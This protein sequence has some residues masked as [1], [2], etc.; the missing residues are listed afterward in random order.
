MG[1]IGIREA[2]W[3]GYAFAEYCFQGWQAVFEI[4]TDMESLH[5]GQGLG[6]WGT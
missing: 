1:Y 6:Y 5:M 2:L 3:I 4:H